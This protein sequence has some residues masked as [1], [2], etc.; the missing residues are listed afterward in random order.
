MIVPVASTTQFIRSKSLFELNDGYLRYCLLCEAFLLLFLTYVSVCYIMWLPF[1]S[2]IIYSKFRNIYR[3][4][5]VCMVINVKVT[6]VTQ[7][8]ER[9]KVGCSISTRKNVRLNIFISS[10]VARAL[11]FHCWTGI[12]TF[13]N[14]FLSLNY[15]KKCWNKKCCFLS[16]HV[17][18]F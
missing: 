3:L 11:D 6:I 2:H 14:I 8:H 16:S 4:L 15:F 5:S 13:L 12:S 1:V 9:A 7:E 17:P 10:M 18:A